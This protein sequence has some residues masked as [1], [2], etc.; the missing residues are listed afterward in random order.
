LPP[1]HAGNLVLAAAESRRWRSQRLPY[2]VTMDLRA[3]SPGI[4]CAVGSRRRQ[5]APSGPMLA[6]CAMR[7]GKIGHRNI[8]QGARLDDNP[9]PLR[10]RR[11]MPR[12]RRVITR[13]SALA[14]C[15]LRQ[16]RAWLDESRRVPRPRQRGSCVPSGR[17]LPGRRRRDRRFSLS[18]VVTHLRA[19]ATSRS[20][21]GRRGDHLAVACACAAPFRYWFSL[22][23]RDARRGRS[24]S[25]YSSGW[26]G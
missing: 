3:T 18:K 23:V 21:I 13:R 1:A 25:R 14:R 9:T 15:V 7:A 20:R 11:A 6:T 17:L 10:P 24:G 19:A 22:I 16:R 12:V 2:A 26:R 8:R 4:R 5:R